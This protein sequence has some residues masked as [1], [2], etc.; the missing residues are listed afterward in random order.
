MLFRNQPPA[1]RF[2]VFS[3]STL[4]IIFFVLSVTFIFVTKRFGYK[5]AEDKLTSAAE[6]IKLHLATV[7]N[8]EIA[9]ARKMA[10]SPA[11]RRYFM[12]PLNS[13]LKQNAFEELE[14]Y[15]KNF[16]DKSLFWVNNFD[17]MFYRS[18][19]APYFVDA[20]L[21]ENYWYNMT[22]YETD[23]YNFN[24]NYNPD[25]DET[26]LWVNVPIFSDADEP[27]GMA[28]TSI[29]IDDFLKSIILIDDA[30]SLFIFNKFSEITVARDK[31]L[32]L[33]KTLLPNHM[34]ST[35]TKITSIAKNLHNSG[36]IFFT[37][38]DIMYYVYPIPL[39]HW[40][41]VFSSSISFF[42]L[43]DPMIAFVFISIFIICAFI[44][45]IFNMYV[46][47]IYQELVFANE[48]A[49]MASR[50]K[51]AFLA[52]M[53]HEIRTPLNAITGLCELA[54]REHG[55]P[56][57]LENIA[58]IKRA[59]ECL[60]GIVND[61]LD[62]SKIE[63]GLLAINDAPYDTASLLNDVLT[64]IRVKAT[65][66]SLA[67]TTDIVSSMPC[68]MTGDAGRIRQILLNL[69][70]NAV[71]YTEEGGSIRLAV[72][73]EK[74]AE[75]AMCLTL[76]VEDSGIG[77][78][79]EE[80]PRIFDDFARLDEK[81]NSAIE[82]TG[83]GLPITR[84]LCRA[85]GGDLV[86]ASEYGKGSVFTATLMQSV[87]EWKPMNDP[88][89]SVHCPKSSMPAFAAPEAE[90]LLVDDFPDNL[91][92]V[93]GLLRPYR[94]RVRACRNGREALEL[95]QTR[96]FDLV[97]MDHMMPE[98][99]GIEA[100]TRIRALGGRFVTLPI[101]AL[102]A[103]AMAGMREFFLERGFSDYISKPIAPVMLD[104]MLARWIPEE[105]Q[106]AAE[107]QPHI[108]QAQAGVKQGPG[109]KQDIGVTGAARAALTVQRLDLLN[110]YRWHFVNGLPADAAYFE[111]FCALVEIM[112]VPP[113]MRGEMASLTA[114]GRRGDAA[115]IQR[116]LPGLYEAVAASMRSNRAAT[117]LT[118]ILGRLKTALDTGDENSIDSVMDTLRS[119]DEL[120]DEA[121]EL[122][123][124]LYN[125][126]LM[127]EKEKAAGGLAVWMSIF[128]RKD[129]PRQANGRD[130]PA[131]GS[132]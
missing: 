52:R 48:Q 39:M 94:M 51:S 79:P 68:V 77:I 29:N 127:D 76:V 5:A 28:G 20:S 85:M 67:L 11:I 37:D 75:N 90:V 36:P 132:A 84:S 22:L 72:S 86:V 88:A 119:M 57:A 55:K 19:K 97:L 50:A 40:Y 82:G 105:K 73:G 23:T 107:V 78:K 46:T 59:G 74:T 54:R 89:S 47:K 116:L 122:Y 31:R 109:L 41:C 108:P 12:N 62:F 128:G 101:V 70:G 30:V 10:D 6:N 96:V 106:G 53:S 87:D 66:K 80:L 58:G 13:Q 98:M 25:L 33:D 17:K 44:V 91:R 103:N 1:V 123:I 92:V 124:F 83:L 8:S 24:I 15:E 21:P 81:R 112:D 126:L 115:E 60:L 38:N 69:L 32:V 43:I 7:V 63:S 16:E 99:D 117:G 121:R 4:V 125:A 113:Q 45:V 49:D 61:I 104:T 9:L 100:T 2:K 111:K 3:V 118:D 56:E 42:T 64:V 120:N 93:E 65:E 18:N 35:G 102:T 130:C 71:K 131:T 129:T 34:G 114:A 95:V 110:H 14:S 27:I 26:N